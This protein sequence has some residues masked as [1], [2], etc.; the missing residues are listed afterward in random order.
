MV[1]VAPCIVFII[2]PPSTGGIPAQRSRLRR[3]HALMHIP[4]PWQQP[5]GWEA[6]LGLGAD[7]RALWSRSR[8]GAR[9]QAPARSRPGGPHT[10]GS[11]GGRQDPRLLLLRCSALP[12]AA[13]AAAKLP[14]PQPPPHPPDRRRAG[15]EGPGPAP[16]A[17]PTAQERA[18][19]GKASAAAGAAATGASAVQP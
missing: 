7:P 10:A 6:V 11:T 2:P 9:A 18:G 19:E 14:Q 13:A 16:Q 5:P 1:S 4:S 12:S 15:Q 3:A 17:S 8:K